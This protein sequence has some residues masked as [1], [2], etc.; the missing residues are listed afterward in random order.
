V[1]LAACRAAAAA[2]FLRGRFSLPDAFLAAGARAVVAA[3][4]EI[5]DAD[6]HRVFDELHRRLDAGEP[7]AHALAAIRAADATWVRHLVLFE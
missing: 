1:V 5:P 3:D 2:P 4:V 6:A 7:I